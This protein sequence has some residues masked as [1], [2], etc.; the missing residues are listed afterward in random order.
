ML[1][2]RASVGLCVRK[3]LLVTVTRVGGGGVGP[4]RLFEGC[5]KHPGRSGEGLGPC[6]GGA[7][8]GASRASR[9]PEFFL[10]YLS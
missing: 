3:M 1:R 8:E 10:G 4:G 6:G 5:G 2:R 7:G 9:I